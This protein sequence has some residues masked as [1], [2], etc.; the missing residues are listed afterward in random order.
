MA[1]KSLRLIAA[2]NRSSASVAVFTGH[3]IGCQDK[4]RHSWTRYRNK[5]TLRESGVSVDYL[6]GAAVGVGIAGDRM[7]LAVVREG[8][9]HRQPFSHRCFAFKWATRPGRHHHQPTAADS[10]LASVS[11]YRAAESNA[12]HVSQR[13]FDRPP[14]AVQTSRQDDGKSALSQWHNKEE[15]NE[16]F[17]SVL[18]GRHSRLFVS[19]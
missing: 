16:T 1:V 9:V 2:K 6:A 18:H 15:S 17:W 8:H 14:R 5:M 11:R 3:I 4:T 19:D 10:C 7:V 13:D 12:Q